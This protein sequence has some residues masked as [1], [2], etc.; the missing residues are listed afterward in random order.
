M[1]PIRFFAA[2]AVACA[3]LL[4]A[5]PGIAVAAPAEQQTMADPVAGDVELAHGKSGRAQDDDRYRRRGHDGDRHRARDRHRDRH[6]D[7]RRHRDRFHW[8]YDY[9]ERWR[10][11]RHPRKPYW[12]GRHLP[13]H[14][15]FYVIRN[16]WDY[17]LPPPPHGHYYVRD[18][19]DVFLV[20]EATRTIIDA[21]IL[22]ELLGR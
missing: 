13:P 11:G 16:Y 22:L 20:I 19:D 15:R 18:N 2:T 21:F 7:W 12:K 5:L 17:H 4:F 14:G 8:D 6:G 10:T 1:T 9:R 3:G